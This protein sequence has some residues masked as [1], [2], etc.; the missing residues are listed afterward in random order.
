MSEL[1]EALEDLISR[2]ALTP[3]QE[4][5]AEEAARA[6]VELVKAEGGA[7]RLLEQAEPPRRSTAGATLAGLPLHEAARRVL[8]KYGWPMHA[9]ELALRIKAEG[10]RHPRTR[11]AKQ[12][13][14]VFQLAARLPRYPNI[15]RRVAPNTFAL[16][17]WGDSPPR[18]ERPRP[19]APL[20]SGPGGNLSEWI[21][22]HP[23]APFEDTEWHSS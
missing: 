20:F 19:R 16:T 8:E 23:E 10:W 14:I 2:P 7:R 15:F 6:L 5:T 13:Q 22:E 1:K 9:K 12:D 11:N 4:R 17:K 21:G 18:S 3:E